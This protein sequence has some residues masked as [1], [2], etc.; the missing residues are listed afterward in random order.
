M[1]VQ[2]TPSGLMGELLPQ[3]RCERAAAGA[4][5]TLVRPA[6][7][8]CGP[9]PPIRAGKSSGSVS[10]ILRAGD[11]CDFPSELWSPQVNGRYAVVGQDLGSQHKHEKVPFY[12]LIPIAKDRNPFSAVRSG[13]EWITGP[14]AACEQDVLGNWHPQRASGRPLRASIGGGGAGG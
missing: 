5:G 8:W 14:W 11:A 13:A 1:S 7:V 12:P 3:K 10:A 6:S 9:P 2:P 4:S